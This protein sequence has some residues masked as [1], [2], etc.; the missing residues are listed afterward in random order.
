[1]RILLWL[2]EFLTFETL[3]YDP[4][5]QQMMQVLVLYIVWVF[6]TLV[7]FGLACFLMSMLARLSIAINN[8]IFSWFVLMLELVIW[9]VYLLSILVLTRSI[10]AFGGAAMLSIVTL[11]LMMMR[12]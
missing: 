9:V 7:T 3:S 1:M 12:E 5:K 11:L 2:K 4:F 10:M 6:L 8:T